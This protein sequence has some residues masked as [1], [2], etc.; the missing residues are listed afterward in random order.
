MR[1]GQ[2]FIVNPQLIERTAEVVDRRRISADQRVHVGKGRCVRVRIGGT[3]INLAVD[4][5]RHVLRGI[6]YEDDM[7]PLAVADVGLALRVDRSAGP[8]LGL[9]CPVAIHLQAGSRSVARLVL[10]DNRLGTRVAGT[11]P[12]RDRVRL[13]RIGCTEERQPD[14]YGDSQSK[15]GAVAKRAGTGESTRRQS[16]RHSRTGSS[17]PTILRRDSSS[18]RCRT[19]S[20]ESARFGPRPSRR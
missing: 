6:L 14:V 4:V 5:D 11:N 1:R 15:L 20:R 16:C 12:G 2:D 18:Y 9:A 17:R 7:V 19:N 8:P 3:R 13:S 10:C